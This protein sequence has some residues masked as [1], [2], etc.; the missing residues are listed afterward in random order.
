MRLGW[1]AW[2]ASLFVAGCLLLTLPGFCAKKSRAS[3]SAEPARAVLAGKARA[4][5]SRGR[6]DMAIQLWQQILLSAPENTEA[7]A[8]LALDYKLTGSNDHA[9][10]TLDRLRKANPNDPSIA[11]IESVV[12][13]ADRIVVSY[14]PQGSATR[15]RWRVIP[16]SDLPVVFQPVP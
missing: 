8:G 1:G 2:K 6:P 5:E 12:T 16:R 10:Q 15:Q 9:K 14:R 3:N 13:A 4:L 11:R 7:L